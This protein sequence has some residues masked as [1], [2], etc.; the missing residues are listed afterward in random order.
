[1]PNITSPRSSS[2]V[3]ALGAASLLITLAV[4]DLFLSSRS[5]YTTRPIATASYLIAQAVPIVAG[6]EG[7]A[8]FMDVIVPL[9]GRTGV[10]APSD[11]IIASLVS[12]ILYLV[13]PA[14]PI[15]AH[16]FDKTILTQAVV[17]MLFASGAIISI[18]AAPGMQTFDFL[19]PKRVLCL[20]MED[21]SSNTLSLHI[22]GLD[23]SPFE[24][25]V[26]DLAAKLELEEKP[27]LSE[28]RDDIA[29]W[30]IVSFGPKYPVVSFCSP[31]E[32]K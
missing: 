1:M 15:A 16:R 10:D 13:V 23:P 21:T 6:A 20:Y 11:H 19:H 4:N 26:D 8:S 18:F 27:V 14:L 3:F 31:A 7:M 32:L 29:E 2:Y 25:L 22:A 9:T 28:I 17:L 12:G 5:T 24:H 30:D